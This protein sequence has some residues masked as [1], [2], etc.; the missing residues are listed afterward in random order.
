MG[1][2]HGVNGGLGHCGERSNLLA[3][4]VCSLCSMVMFAISSA[5]PMVDAH[6]AQGRQ[7]VFSM[8]PE[9]YPPYFISEAGG[10][11]RGMM[12][13]AMRQICS[14]LG[15]TL[16][17]VYYPEKRQARMLDTGAIDARPKA[18]E[19][20]KNP[21]RYSWTDP[22]VNA[23]DV[24][25]FPRDRPLVYQ[26][27]EDLEGKTIIAHL[28][29]AYPVLEPLF[30]S[31]RVIRV[32][33]YSEP[34]MLDAL[35]RTRHDAAIMNKQVALWLIKTTERFQGRFAFS[36]K[37]VDSVGYRIMFTTLRDWAPFVRNFN[38]EL[39][40]MKHDGSLD[41]IM[42]PYQARN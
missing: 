7:I 29:Y 27:A 39:S 18:K 34:A 41:R 5:V 21:E 40:R 15:Y 3:R 19:W 38:R 2:V 28:G 42:A 10:A 4:V 26:R 32:D 25:V 23:T 1:M 37:A 35:G 17:V 11:A 20:V 12:L 13:D 30:S 6:A 36:E 8:P 14:R 33:E 22:I 31:R 9:G 16:D 24:F